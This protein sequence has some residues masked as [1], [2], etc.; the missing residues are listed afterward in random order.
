MGERWR[1][2]RAQEQLVGDVNASSHDLRWKKKNCSSMMV[3][4]RDLGVLLGQ[5]LACKE[6]RALKQW[7]RQMVY[8]RDNLSVFVDLIHVNF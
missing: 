2:Q 7:K 3:Q 4:G 8:C 6:Q 5:S 1:R